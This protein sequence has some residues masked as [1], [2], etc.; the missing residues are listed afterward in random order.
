MKN[1]EFQ[2][3]IANDLAKITGIIIEDN[4]KTPQNGDK[5]LIINF[6]NSLPGNLVAKL[7]RK[8]YCVINSVLPVPIG[9]NG[10]YKFQYEI[11]VVDGEGYTFFQPDYTLLK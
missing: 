11:T 10:R 4:D 2:K 5:V 1:I 7:S 3:Q 9:E 8:E 6:D